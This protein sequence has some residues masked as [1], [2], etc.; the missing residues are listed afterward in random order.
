MTEQTK[1]IGPWYKQ[2]WLW[3]VLTPLIAVVIIASILIFFAITTADGIVKDDYYKVARGTEIDSTKTQ[4]AQRLG[5]KGEF[6]VDSL[7]GDVRLTLNSKDPLAET[8]TVDLVHPAH[9]K[10]DQTLTLRSVNG[11]GIYLGSLTKQLDGKRYLI[12]STPDG[13]WNL[14]TEILP[15]YDQNS[16]K[17][18]ADN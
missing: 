11:T 13:R 16:F 1:D 10:Y 7:T 18:G 4:E 5:L 2:S 12:V 14:R 8:L 9:Q 17:L 6:M 3:F 15:P